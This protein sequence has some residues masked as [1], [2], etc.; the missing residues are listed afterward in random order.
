MGADGSPENHLVA[1]PPRPN[2]TAL[3]YCP[4][5]GAGAV[6]PLAPAALPAS[7]LTER[8]YL[9]VAVPGAPGW[10]VTEG[11]RA[12]LCTVEALRRRGDVDRCIVWGQSMG[13]L[14][15]VAIAETPDSG[16]DGVISLCG[17]VAGPVAM[18][19]QALD[20]AWVAAV[21]GRWEK[22]DLIGE[23][24]DAQRAARARVLLRR[25]HETAL[26]RARIA[27]ACAVGQLPTWSRPGTPRPVTPAARQRQQAAIF[28]WAVL[29]PRNDLRARAGG[30][31][32]WNTGVDYAAQLARSGYA[33]LV[34]SLYA[35][36]RA[37]LAA[38]LDRLAAAPR[39][40]ADPEAVARMHTMITPTG[41]LRVPTLTVHQ[42][43]DAAPVVTQAIAYR[44]AVAAA[45]RSALLAQ[46]FIDRPGHCSE[47]PAE[48]LGSIAELE[49]R[50]GT[51]DWPAAEPDRWGS[52][53]DHGFLRPSGP[54]DGCDGR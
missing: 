39:I 8:G 1:V 7:A 12:T 46:R 3:V 47:A 15:A 5:Y 36:C 13:G 45:G 14:A 30:T 29:A 21:L 49:H 43:G 34:G 31:F 17:S 54:R 20:A 4:G 24:P 22:I 16:V 37:H 48:L 32:S 42:N 9:L 27:L 50:L 33:D 19:N 53:P 25:T 11:I 10:S 38:D 40:G 26:G 28:E 6:P 23:V 18:L 44:D 2:G 41:R 52:P 35:S 51:G